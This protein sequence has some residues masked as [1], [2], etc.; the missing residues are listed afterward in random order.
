[1]VIDE[2]GRL[3]P[4]CYGIH[5]QLALGQLG[6]DL[7]VQVAHYKEEGWRGLASLL[8]LAFTRLGARGEQFVDWFYHVVETSYVE[9]S[10][11]LSPYT[12]N[13]A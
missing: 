13:P 12:A 8:D 11:T 10:Y 6:S 5:P 2:T 3:L 4:L 1:L 7:T 9:T